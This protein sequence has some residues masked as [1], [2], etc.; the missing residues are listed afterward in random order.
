[1]TA[2]ALPH[3]LLQLQLRLLLQLLQLQL[4]CSGLP[5]VGRDYWR[6]HLFKP[7]RNVITGF[8][9][10]TFRRMNQWTALNLPQ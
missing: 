9:D 10:G 8:A 4:Q 5:D 7:Q 6:V 1:M 3:S 2:A